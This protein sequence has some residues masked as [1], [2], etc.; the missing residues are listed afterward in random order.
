MTSVDAIDI[1]DLPIGFIIGAVIL[2]HLVRIFFSSL[3]SFPNFP[4]STELYKRSFFLLEHAIFSIWGYYVIIY[5]PATSHSW[6]FKPYL[7][8]A[9]PP[10]FPSVLF[11][12]FYIAKVG[13]HVED[14]L[15]RFYEMFYAHNSPKIARKKELA[16]N[17]HVHHINSQLQPR[18]VSTANMHSVESETEAKT[19]D[20]DV[21][22]NITG[23]AGASFVQRTISPSPRSTELLHVSATSTRGSTTSENK[24]GNG[25]EYTNAASSQT[26]MDALSNSTTFAN[27][28]A[29][30]N[31]SSSHVSAA[32]ASTAAG[33]DVMMD[34]HH[35]ATAVLCILS[36][37]SGQDSKFAFKLQCFAQYYGV[38][39]DVQIV[40]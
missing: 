3:R 31:I 32:N 5:Y 35:I 33:A 11:H 30:T 9:Y 27:A 34:V 8:W 36:Y 15:Y 24:S 16:C 37:T 2:K 28:S 23:A 25:N 18:A 29:N 17:N 21:S 40:L 1:G 13:T 4:E 10:Q 19:Y 14:L 6:F 22:S 26:S 12:N 7:C 38:G 20:A 39:W